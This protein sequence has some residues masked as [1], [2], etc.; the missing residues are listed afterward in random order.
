[1]DANM[2]QASPVP[3]RGRPHGPMGN[4]NRVGPS[5]P[6]TPELR[7]NMLLRAGGQ[8]PRNNAQPHPWPRRTRVT[9]SILLFLAP[10]CH[11]SR[12]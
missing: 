7:A 1:M 10:A 5:H 3:S 4:Q 6:S 12:I 9:L 11:S 8:G 2:C